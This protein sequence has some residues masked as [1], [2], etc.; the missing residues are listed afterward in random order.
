MDAPKLKHESGDDGNRV[1]KLEPVQTIVPCC[2]QRSKHRSN[3]A[4]FE[5]TPTNWVIPVECPTTTQGRSA[6]SAQ[7]VAKY[8]I[9]TLHS[10]NHVSDVQTRR[11]CL[12]ARAQSFKITGTKTDRYA[13]PT[14]FQVHSVF[15]CT[16]DWGS[17]LSSSV[18]LQI[19]TK[20][21]SAQRS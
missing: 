17:S 6:A 12:V 3:T 4:S 1:K 2:S 18:K 7:M 20:T 8:F 9:V 11:R 21:G 19:L 10:M 13:E 15:C 5:H 14:G 16:L